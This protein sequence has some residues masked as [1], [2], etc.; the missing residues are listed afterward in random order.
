MNATTT[1]QYRY[2]LE[3][4]CDASDPREDFD[5]FATMVCWHRRSSLGDRQPTETEMDALS[6]KGFP[7]L[8]RYLS[9]TEGAVYVAPLGLYEHSGMTMWLGGGTSPFDTAGWDSGTVGFIYITRDQLK[10]AG[11]EPGDTVEGEDV[12]AMIARQEVEEYDQFLTG[13]VWGYIIETVPEC[14][15]DDCDQEE[16]ECGC[17][18]HDGAEHVDSCWGFYGREWAEEAAKEELAGWVERA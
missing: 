6:R 14:D 15:N 13:D 9:M 16:C 11:F 8:Q 4:D 12:A 2:R 17:V 10:A 5:H 3:Q 1:T 7:L 18:C